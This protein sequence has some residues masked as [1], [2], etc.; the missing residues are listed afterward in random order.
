MKFDHEGT[1]EV[2]FESSGARTWTS[3]DIISIDEALGLSTG[4]DCSFFMDIPDTN[5]ETR[6]LTRAERLELANHYIAL[7]TRY[8]DAT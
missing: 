4:C 8:R 5:G 1:S 2:V 7:W 6:E 3:C